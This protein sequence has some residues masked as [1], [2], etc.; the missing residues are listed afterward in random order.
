MVGC[1][2]RPDDELPE[3][4]LE[5]LPDDPPVLVGVLV[6]VLVAVG[7]GVEVVFDGLGVLLLLLGCGVADVDEALGVEEALSSVDE[8]ELLLGVDEADADELASSLASAEE[9]SEEDS[10]EDSEELD[11]GVLL[12]AGPTA[13]TVSKGTLNVSDLISVELSATP[14]TKVVLYVS[15]SSPSFPV[16]LITVSPGDKELSTTVCVPCGVV[17]VLVVWRCVTRCTRSMVLPL[18]VSMLTRSCFPSTIP[19]ESRMEAAGSLPLGATELFPS[20]IT[21]TGP[22]RLIT[23]PPVS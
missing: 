4:P 23:M 17:L 9:E 21:V 5:E 22:D 11:D 20:A 8:L 15:L 3:D 12:S 19:F 6:A 16:C 13:I 10:E 2:K 18:S 7:L 14:S 1:H